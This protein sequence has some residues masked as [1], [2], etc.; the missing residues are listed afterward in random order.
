MFRYIPVVC[1]LAAAL[2]TTT[3]TTS[4]STGAKVP[5]R[6]LQRMCVNVNFTHNTKSDDG[7]SNNTTVTIKFKL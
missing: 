7:S 1:K 5:V 2:T 4:T 3:T 6:L